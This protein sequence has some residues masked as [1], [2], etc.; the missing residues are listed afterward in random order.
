MSSKH[1]LVPWFG[2]P[3]ATQASLM[4]AAIQE[5]V[6]AP[7]SSSGTYWSGDRGS[8][9]LTSP[10]RRD[11]DNSIVP[12]P[13]RG[14]LGGIF[15]LH[16]RHEEESYPKQE[17]DLLAPLLRKLKPDDDANDGPPQCSVR[18]VDIKNPHRGCSSAGR[19]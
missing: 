7:G 12:Y 9:G 19:T 1:S 8:L 5:D 6:S 11:L 16:P 14:S 10:S 18:R 13:G 4:L 17:Q 2:A 15:T 3:E